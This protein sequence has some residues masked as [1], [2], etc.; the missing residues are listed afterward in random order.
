MERIV[1]ET[2]EEKAKESLKRDVVEKVLSGK[3]NG[4]VFKN[5]LEDCKEGKFK[6]ANNSF[7]DFWQT[8]R[9]TFTTEEEVEVEPDYKYHL[10]K[11][12]V[13]VNEASKKLDKSWLIS[14]E[15]PEKCNDQIQRL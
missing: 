11:R 3:L 7:G 15:G 5:A 4:A 12:G 10:T 13:T 8:D 9:Y 6:F 2:V 1:I 14:L